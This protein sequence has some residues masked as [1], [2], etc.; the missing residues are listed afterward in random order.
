MQTPPEGV[1]GWH[2]A[3]TPKKQRIPKQRAKD[4]FRSRAQ[5]S[6]SLGSHLKLSVRFS[7]VRVDAAAEG[8]QSFGWGFI[9]ICLAA[10][11]D[12]FQEDSNKRW[13]CPGRS[14]C[15]PREPELQCTSNLRRL[16]PRAPGRSRVPIVDSGSTAIWSGWIQMLSPSGKPILAMEAH[17]GQ[18]TFRGV[19]R[20]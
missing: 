7:A 2:N 19:A 17:P 20:R 16:H 6:T 4:G 13:L 18:D 8:S 10:G 12:R 3:Q 1:S 14:V 9:G 5:G 11:A 15:E